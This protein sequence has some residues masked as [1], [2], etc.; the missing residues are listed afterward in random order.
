M[1]VIGIANDIDSGA[2]LLV[3][4]ALVAVVNEERFSRV[5]QEDC[6][7]SRSIEYVLGKAGLRMGDVDAVT[8]A[9]AKGFDGTWLT[10]Y[11][12]R[13]MVAAQ[14]EEGA[15]ELVRDRIHVELDQD[16]ANI[17][18]LEKFGREGNW[19]DKI[20]YIDHHQA[21]AASA[22]YTSPF[23]EALVITG[24]GR[25][26]FRSATVSLGRGDR[27]E[28]VEWLPTLD[29]L[30]YFYGAITNFLG[31][32]PHRHEGKVTGLAAYGDPQKCLHIMREMVELQDGRIVTKI[33]KYYKPFFS[34]AP[35]L[36][37][38][39]A[40]YRKEDV[41]AACQYQF[42]HVVTGFIR[43]LVQQYGMRNICLAGGVYANVKT[44]QRIM[45]I[46]GVDNI[47]VHPAMG[48]GGLP[49]GGAL[50][51]AI[52]EVGCPRP[53]FTSCYWGPDYSNNEVEGVL[54]GNGLRYEKVSGR[55]KIK[56]TVDL[57]AGDK[58]VGWFQG[59]M[60]FG[61]RALGHR[62]ILCHPFDNGVNDWLNKRL[63][64]TEFMPF[65]PATLE[66]LAQECYMGWKQDHVATRYMT[67]CYE[68]T[69]KM[70]ENS[71]AVVHV[72]GTA[73]PQIVRRE[74][75]PEYH[76]VIEAFYH[77]TGGLSIINTSF[78]QHEEPIVS[79]PADA[80]GS[81]K[82]NNVD[83][84]VIGDFIAECA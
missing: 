9:W 20:V 59:R 8:Y 66:E 31:F 5:K 77:K 76:G 49:L 44:N 27:L 82:N 60:E 53:E 3:D 69:P 36:A 61:P 30:G 80:V 63:H 64:R 37:Q 26:D 11:A 40:G 15:F 71:P 14:R 46:E 65:A 23:A 56:K 34:V 6:F 28:E 38:A 78:N 13:A 32:T 72:D 83:V 10:Q 57:L 35:E 29:S 21:H 70:R 45:E 55:D 39:L 19:S 1:V 24:D 75:N 42:E 51:Y 33:G 7:P 48:D 41:A 4:G 81:L 68:C 73:R 74:D 22:Y 54:Q 52:E 67:V 18:E 2:A 62:S 16:R 17:E 12:E 79:S 25:G 50:K 84:L 43:R 58:V 47:F